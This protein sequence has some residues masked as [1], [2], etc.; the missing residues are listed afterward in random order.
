MNSLLKAI[1]VS[2]LTLAVAGCRVCDITGDESRAM[3][4]LAATCPP[5]SAIL[6]IRIERD[7]GTFAKPNIVTRLGQE[8]VYKNV[9]EYIY[10]TKYNV[11]VS[12]TNGVFAAAIEPQ[13]FTMRE[14]GV[15]VQATPTLV[16]GQVNVDLGVEIVDEPTWKNYGGTMTASN[17]VKSEMLMEQPF[18]R[19]QSVKTQHLLPPGKPT[20]IH[21]DGLT[22]TITPRI[23]SPDQESSVAK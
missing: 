7:G 6:E 16:E 19:V 9:T 3:E 21:S 18:F 14:V 1:T 23:P 22:I 20:T 17:G 11:V 2:F 12:G 13:D 15:V 4:S 8:G 5:G 10:P